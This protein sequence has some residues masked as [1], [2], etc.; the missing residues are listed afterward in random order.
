MERFGLVAVHRPAHHLPAQTV[1]APGRFL[2]GTGA[3]R[4]G[5]LVESDPKGFGGRQKDIKERLSPNE[6]G[7][8]RSGK[9]ASSIKERKRKREVEVGEADKEIVTKKTSSV[10]KLGFPSL[11][12]S[13][14]NKS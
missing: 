3:G 14:N 13:R 6:T 9:G 10:R 1:R 4:G 11:N 5:S 7:G 2:R 8:G 12:V